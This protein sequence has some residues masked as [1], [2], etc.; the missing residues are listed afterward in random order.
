[1]YRPSRL[2]HRSPDWCRQ[3]HKGWPGLEAVCVTPCLV[4]SVRLRARA[5][6]S[7]HARSFMEFGGGSRQAVAG[8]LWEFVW[9]APEVAGRLLMRFYSSDKDE[10]AVCPPGMF[11]CNNSCNSPRDRSGFKRKRTHTLRCLRPCDQGVWP[12][13]DSRDIWKQQEVSRRSS[14]VSV[15]VCLFAHKHAFMNIVYHPGQFPHLTSF[16]RSSRTLQNMVN[17]PLFIRFL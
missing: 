17:E 12:F 4:Q 11:R 15:F 8:R 14:R 1:M 3:G 10:G 13:D 6:L 5:E 16:N 9:C 7:L 2:H